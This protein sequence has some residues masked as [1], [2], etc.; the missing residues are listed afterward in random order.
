MQQMAPHLIRTSI[1]VTVIAIERPW[2]LAEAQ[3]CTEAWAREACV[4]SHPQKAKTL[5]NWMQ[6][7]GVGRAKY[8]PCI[9]PT[10][11][12]LIFLPWKATPGCV[13]YEN[14]DDVRL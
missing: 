12:E 7:G 11:H 6:V 4:R 8:L 13:Q 14:E 9:P 1:L 3:A 10:S 5:L 2:F